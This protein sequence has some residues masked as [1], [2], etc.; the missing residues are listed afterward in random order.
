MCVCVG[1]GGGGGGGS[2]LHRD[3]QIS[4]RSLKLGIHKLENKRHLLAS[5]DVS[6]SVPLLFPYAKTSFIQDMAYLV[7][8]MCIKPFYDDNKI[9]E[10]HHEKRLHMRK[11]RR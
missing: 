4:A 1:G 7:K 8:G 10:P 11:Q 6:L 5:V 3:N 2:C 9:Y